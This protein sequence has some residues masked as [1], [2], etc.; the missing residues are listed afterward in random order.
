MGGDRGFLRATCFESG[1]VP[2]ATYDVGQIK[3][4]GYALFKG[5]NTIQNAEQEKL[6]TEQCR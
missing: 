6:P 1:N 2:W 5:V 3:E 4:G